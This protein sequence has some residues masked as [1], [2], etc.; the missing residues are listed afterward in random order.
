M[1]TKNS[2]TNCV[3]RQKDF[4]MTTTRCDVSTN[5]IR[6]SHN[7]FAIQTKWNISLWAARKIARSPKT[8]RLDILKSYRSKRKILIYEDKKGKCR[9]KSCNFL[10]T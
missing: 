2:V 9:G 1:V 4:L 8:Y 5:E 10:L 6:A 3:L 7:V